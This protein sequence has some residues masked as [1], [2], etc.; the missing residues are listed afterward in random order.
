MK[1]LRRQ[2]AGFTL[3]E[4]LISV[5]VLILVLAAATMAFL[6]QNGA[7]QAL[8]MSRLANA[9]ARDSMLQMEVALRQAGW[10][11]EPRYAFDF[12][13]NCTSQPC[14]D[15]ASGPDELWFV[16]RN[17][18]YRWLAE[19]EAGCARCYTGYALKVD[20][21]NLAAHTL[22]ITL[23]AGA[24]V[25]RGRT[26]LLT[27]ASGTDPVMLTL[28]A[29]VTGPG[30]VTIVPAGANSVPYNNYN[31]LKACHGVTGASIFL[32]ERYHYLVRT[33]GTTSWLMLDTGIDA[34]NDGTLPP[35]DLDDLIP[36]AK[37]VEDMQVAYLMTPNAA[38]T[39]PDS[40]A[41]WI[42]GNNSALSSAEEPNRSVTAPVYDTPTD[43]PSRANAHP[44]NIMGVR[45]TLTVRSERT[46][47]SMPTNWTGDTIDAP[48]NRTGNLSGGRF[49]R[50][51]MVTEITLRN[52][53]ARNAFTF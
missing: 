44:A 12:Y 7:L 14:R 18:N 24:T 25:Q 43:D 15:S 11:I 46:D 22:V 8:D 1:I 51:P 40:N 50:Y 39:A 31:G 10:G 3:V 23:P 28:S 45:V 26:V 53:S 52:M 38:F 37:N 16:A 5:A 19:G 42:F 49:R 32:V 33:Y 13:T 48:E 34:D 17:P 47:P 9:S 2:R 41:D 36:V 27:C 20:S 29:P 35:T 21:V 30:A 6:A 4:L